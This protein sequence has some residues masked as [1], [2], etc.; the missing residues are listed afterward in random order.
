MNIDFPE[1]PPGVHPPTAAL[2]RIL[3]FKGVKNPISDQPYSEALLLGIGGGIDIGYILFQFPHLPHPLLVLGFR[4]QW[5]NTQAF[6]RDLTKRLLISVKFLEFEAG[7]KA[8]EELQK[9]LNDGKPS[10]LWVDKAHLPY[11]HLPRKLK[12]FINYQVTAY[13][14][15][16]R[17]LRLRLD[18]LSSHPIE[19]SEKTLTFARANLSQNNFLMMVYQKAESL[20]ANELREAS[21]EGIRTCATRLTRPTKAIGISNLENWAIKLTDHQDRHGWP[22]TF[23]NQQGLYNALRTIYESVK[24]NGTDGFA[25]RKMYADFLH[26]AAGILNNPALHAITGQ[27]L[28]LS[29]HWSNLAENA[30]PSKVPV[31]DRVKNLLNKKHVAYQKYDIKTFENTVDDLEKLE[32][33]LAHSFPFNNSKSNQ[34][35]ERLSSQIQLIA[36]LE[37]NAAQRLRDVTRR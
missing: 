27:Y 22:Q 3:N 26:E 17:L 5:N 25:L 4:N 2:A 30:L 24:I 15:D 20:N 31:F 16:G 8:Q 6:L 19:I 34:L 14:R 9:A 12:G 7:I 21:L 36:E 32:E 1:G 35:F 23:Q 18:D 11:H 10:I 37:T 13:A 33:K 29:N 28:Q